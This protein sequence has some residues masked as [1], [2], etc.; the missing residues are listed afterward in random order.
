MSTNLKQII[1][2]QI[3]HEV[4]TI[5]NGLKRNVNR[6]KNYDK[7]QLKTAAGDLSQNKMLASTD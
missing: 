2:K 6:L 3:S 1:F 7:E 5:T 4:K